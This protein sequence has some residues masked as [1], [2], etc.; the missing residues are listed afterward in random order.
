SISMH[1]GC[2]PHG[3]D[4][5]CEKSTRSKRKRNYED[6][7]NLIQSKLDCSLSHRPAGVFH[8]CFHSMVVSVSIATL[9][10]QTWAAAP[11][12]RNSASQ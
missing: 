5:V 11:L 2:R 7:E 6:H 12:Y 9:K 1:I 4:I 3:I 8:V 10:I